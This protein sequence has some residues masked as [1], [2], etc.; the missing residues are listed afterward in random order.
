VKISAPES[1]LVFSDGMP[2]FIQQCSLILSAFPYLQYVFVQKL[3][4]KVLYSMWITENH[5][6]HRQNQ[7]V[8]TGTTAA[9]PGS[10]RC[11]P[12]EI[13]K[14][15]IPLFRLDRSIKSE[16]T[17]FQVQYQLKSTLVFPFSHSLA[18]GSCHC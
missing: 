18:K 6:V 16:F 7:G 15:R 13:A 12:P 3:E 11:K 9:L 10:R 5:T 1:E 17:T 14:T 8:S 2:F 4:G